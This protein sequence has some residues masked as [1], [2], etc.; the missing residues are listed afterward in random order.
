[1]SNKL[2]WRMRMTNLEKIRTMPVK[3]LASFLEKLDGDDLTIDR[4]YCS[5]VCPMHGESGCQVIDDEISPCEETTV[6][7][8]IVAWLEHEVEE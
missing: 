6:L 2:Y 1:M 4:R 7:E 8:H 3:E 5:E